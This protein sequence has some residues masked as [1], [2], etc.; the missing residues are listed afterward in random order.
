MTVF[1]SFQWTEYLHCTFYRKQGGGGV[2][3]CSKFFDVIYGRPLTLSVDFLQ[4]NILL[5]NQSLILHSSVSAMATAE[6]IP[7]NTSAHICPML[8]EAKYK[9]KLL[10]RKAKVSMHV[11]YFAQEVLNESWYNLFWYKYKPLLFCCYQ[12]FLFTAPYLNKKNLRHT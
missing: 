2:G 6:R 9:Q 5:H 11:H 8:Y 10:I 3:K 1:F 7:W 4:L 12:P